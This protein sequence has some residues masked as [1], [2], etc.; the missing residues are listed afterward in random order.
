MF[1][2]SPKIGV[3]LMHKAIESELKQKTPVFK[4]V[5]MAREK[6]IYFDI[7]QDDKI[8]RY[9]YINQSV[10]SAIDVMSKKQLKNASFIIDRVI[11]DAENKDYTFSVYY[12]NEAGEKLF[13]KIKL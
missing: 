9:P 4:M 8:R 10:F 12:R 3:Q 6:Q 1:G 7:P 11:I 5:Y 2:I 13:N